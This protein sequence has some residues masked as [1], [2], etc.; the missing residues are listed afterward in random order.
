MIYYIHDWLQKSSRI[1]QRVFPQKQPRISQPIGL[2]LRTTCLP[3]VGDRVAGML[4]VVGAVEILPA[5]A[6]IGEAVGILLVI[7][8]EDCGI[9][10]DLVAPGDPSDIA[11][12]A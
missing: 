5:E 12:R 2:T 1:F 3:T 6:G 10:D 11:I 4:C 7:A 8:G 9:I